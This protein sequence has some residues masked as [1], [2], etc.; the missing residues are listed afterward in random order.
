MGVYNLI[1]I[2][3]RSTLISGTKSSNSGIKPPLMDTSITT[4]LFIKVKL[5]ISERLF[6]LQKN[7]IFLL[8]IYKVFSF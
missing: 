3:C 7:G 4:E 8:G 6:K 1:K 5:Y 2:N